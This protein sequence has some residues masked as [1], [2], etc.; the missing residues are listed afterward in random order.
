MTTAQAGVSA[1]QVDVNQAD[2]ALTSLQNTA[3]PSR[4]SSESTAALL[5]RYRLDQARC[6]THSSDPSWKP[7]DGVNCAQIQNLLSFAQNVDS[8]E[9]SSTQAE[10]QQ[11]TAQQGLASAQQNQQSG[12]LQ[13]SQNGR[14]RRTNLRRLSC[15]TSR[16]SR[17]SR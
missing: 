16:R 12:E 9:T 13:D 10:S 11:T 5:T 1:A 14:T 7:S 4:S 6:A 17:A 3:D 15:S 8:A 2:G